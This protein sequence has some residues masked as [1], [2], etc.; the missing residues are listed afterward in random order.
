[1]TEYNIGRPYFSEDQLV[2]YVPGDLPVI[3]VA[4]HG[5]Y[6]QPKEFPLHG[7]HPRNDRNSQEYARGLAKSLHKLTGRFPHLIV[8][9]IHTSR[10]NPAR[11]KWQQIAIQS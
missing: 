4:P 2:E 5:G 1:M 9:H 3:I 11:K 7:D 6:K 10:F 8:N